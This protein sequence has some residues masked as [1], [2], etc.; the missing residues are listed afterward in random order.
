M[1]NGLPRKFQAIAIPTYIH[2]IYV[3]PPSANKMVIK[4][5]G[6]DEPKGALSGNIV[7]VS[8]GKVVIDLQGLQMSGIGNVQDPDMDPHAAVELEWQEDLKFLDVAPLIYQKHDKT[9]L[10]LKLDEFFSACLKETTQQLRG[11]QPTKDHL[12]HYQE[13]LEAFLVQN[14]P[15]NLPTSQ[16]CVT[17]KKLYADLQHTEASEAATA[18]Y[19][20]TKH[21]REIFSGEVEALDLLLEENILH[22]LYDYMQNSE[23]ATFLGLAAHRKPNMRILEIGAGTGGTTATVLPSLRSS[24]DE[25]MFLSYTYTD[26]SSGFFPAAKERFKDFDGLEYKVLD[27]SKDPI[28]QGFQ[29]EEFDLIIACNVCTLQ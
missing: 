8:E 7:A 2:E 26:I 28:D 6:D 3:C 5:T 14:K 20:V 4:A 22:H 11:I 1:S 19:R 12:P 13:W 29:A 23:Y 25:R 17:I 18:I 10:H 15:Q 24:Y 9:K 16:G 21:C 27:I